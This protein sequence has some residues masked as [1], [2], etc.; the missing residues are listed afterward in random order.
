MG[1]AIDNTTHFYYPIVW[2]GLAGKGP[3]EWAE[4]SLD[5]LQKATK[6]HKILAGVDNEV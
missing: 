5:A 4:S 6:L 2:T 1:D 3:F